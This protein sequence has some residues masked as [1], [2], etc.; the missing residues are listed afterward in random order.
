LT[1]PISKIVRK[2]RSN[3]FWSFIFLDSE[4]RDAIFAAYAF[5]RHTD[6]LVDDAPS[7]EKATDRLRAWRS[8]LE[9][10][11]DGSPSEDITIALQPVASRYSI[12]KAYFDDLID[13]VELDLT[14]NRYATFEELQTYC[15]R[16]ASVVGLICIEIFGYTDSRTKDYAINLGM[17]LQLTNILRDVGEDANRDR[18]YLPQDELDR[19]DCSTNQILNREYNQQFQ[20]LMAF[21]CDRARSYYKAAA[22]HLSDAD[23]KSM[24]PAETMGRI[25]SAILAKI[26][27]L[28]YRVFD[29]R[30]TIS[31]LWKVAI[32]AKN[33]LVRS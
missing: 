14:K 7:V 10:C 16:V 25:Y 33:W 29:Q 12:P 4:K 2:A 30:V 27:K 31:T 22:N 3:F 15:Y 32:A 13:G 1:N 24:F 21:Q 26:E 23:R 28:E 6:D 5:A 17:A 18:I 9:A 11:Y 19:F 8:E 20:D